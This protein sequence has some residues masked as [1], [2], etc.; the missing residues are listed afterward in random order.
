MINGG[1][2]AKEEILVKKLSKAESTMKE[3]PKQRKNSRPHEN[4]SWSFGVKVTVVALAI[5]LV[6]A[7][8]AMGGFVNL[9]VAGGLVCAGLVTVLLSLRYLSRSRCVRIII[10]VLTL[11]CGIALASRFIDKY[12]QQSEI[13]VLKLSPS[14]RAAFLQVLQSH[15]SPRLPIAIACPPSREDIC[16]IALDFAQLFR[17]AKW[18]IGVGVRR[19]MSTVRRPGVSIGMGL[20]FE[21]ATPGGAWVEV[22]E[23][24]QTVR[25]A[26]SAAGV[27]FKHQATFGA[28]K[29]SVAVYF[30]IPE[31]H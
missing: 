24:E 27:P 4:A 6:T 11:L 8:L 7:G 29:R 18:D 19:A 28:P 10:G 25:R 31:L 21:G 17:E 22:T 2:G 20:G 12:R 30:G 14:R 26:F 13:A 3:N 16:V 1:Q 9:L 15:V 5:G 23:S